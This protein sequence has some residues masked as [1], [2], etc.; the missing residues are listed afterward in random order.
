VDAGEAQ[1]LEWPTDSTALD[2]FVNDDGHPYP[3]SVV[4]ATWSQ[5]SGPGTV[6]FADAS[7][8]QT[9][10]TFSAPG[11]YELQLVGDDS[12]LQTL[13][14]VIV[15]VNHNVTLS[16]SAT[17]PGSVTLDPPGGTYPAGTMVTVTAAP[18]PDSAFT[19]WSGDL[20]GTTNPESILMDADKS[21]TAAFATLFD[22]TVT[23]TGPGSVTLDPP[24]GTYPAGTV[25]TVTATPDA[26]ASF[27]GF[28]GD[29]T[30]TTSPQQLTVDGD[31]SITATFTQLY[32]L[33]SAATGPGAVTL[34]PPGGVYPAGAA[35]TVTATPDPDA[36]FLGWSGDLAGTTN[37]E[38]VLMDADKSVTGSFASLYDVSLSS[39][40]PGSLA[41]DPPVGP[42]LAGTVVTVTATPD[43]DA[44][45]AGFGGDLTGTTT[46]QQLT[47]D[48]DKTVTGSF[49]AVYDVALNVTGPGSLTLDPPGGSYPDGTVVTVTA[50]PDANASFDG[51]GGDLTGTTTPQQLTVDADKTVSADFSAVLYTLDVTTEGNGTVAV[52][53]PTGP[54]P[55]GSIV[56]LTAQPAEGHL[57]GSWSGDA[58]G[59]AN[60]LDVTMDGNKAVHAK[61]NKKKSASACGIGP[62]LVVGVPLLAWLHRR[63]RQA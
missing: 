46:P 60:P 37:P 47:V 21:V 61:F 42:Y 29:L 57:L 16:T 11:E 56:T 31:K 44:V 54:Y 51:F 23:P 18:D 32:T 5:L 55:A 1:E 38:S 40:G 15:T 13:D 36:A 33:S 17:G 52:D 7:D 8:P 9:T 35:V 63:R 43:P 26:S 19:G 49:L 12:A 59:F 2:G 3:P 14:S 25:V 62:E 48:A 58:S 45:F 10:A 30:G 39:T 53:P 50:T 34:D 4:L 27:D 24:G 41:I 20:A 28:G 22:V 6:T